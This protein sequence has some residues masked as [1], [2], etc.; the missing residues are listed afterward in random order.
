MRGVWFGL[1]LL[2]Y[3]GTIALIAVLFLGACSAAAPTPAQQASLATYEAALQACIARAKLNDAGYYSY[4]AC[5]DGVTDL[6]FHT[7]P[8]GG[9]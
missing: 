5:A 7:S 3:V 4:K 9:K 1:A 6:W 8:D 2:I